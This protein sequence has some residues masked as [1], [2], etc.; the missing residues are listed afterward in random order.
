MLPR[1]EKE[2]GCTEVAG[3][4]RQRQGFR[5]PVR[6][7]RHRPG[8]AWIDLAA[9][10]QSLDTQRLDHRPGG[11]APGHDQLTDTLRYETFGDCRQGLFNERAGSFDAQRSLCRLDL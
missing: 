1:L 8:N 6:T 9:D 4:Q 3:L 2:V 5:E 11:L 10:T 7:Q